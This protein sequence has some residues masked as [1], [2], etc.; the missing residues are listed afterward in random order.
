MLDSLPALLWSLRLPLRVQ[1]YGRLLCLRRR[2]AAQ[3]K[4]KRREQREC[5]APT[6]SRVPATGHHAHG[7]HAARRSCGVEK[8]SRSKRLH[9]SDTRDGDAASADKHAGEGQQ[10]SRSVRFVALAFVCRFIP[11]YTG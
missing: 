10:E 11:S 5:L 1:L 6:D 7:R 9:G 4:R 8:G 3:H 2:H